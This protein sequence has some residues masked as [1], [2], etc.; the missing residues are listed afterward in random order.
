MLTFHHP[1]ALVME[2]VKGGDL[3]NYLYSRGALRTYIS[4]TRHLSSLLTMVVAE[5]QVQYF[6]YQICEALHVSPASR[7]PS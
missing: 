2:F 6:T 7:E 1:T 4:L 5:S 3:L